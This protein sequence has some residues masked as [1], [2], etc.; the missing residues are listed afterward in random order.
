[1]KFPLYKFVWTRTIAEME[2]CQLKKT[3]QVDFSN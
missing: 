2:F 1:M 3:Y